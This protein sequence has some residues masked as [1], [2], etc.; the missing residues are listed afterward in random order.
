M[1]V[2]V[3]ALAATN[4]SARNVLLGHLSCLAAWTREEHHFTVLHHAANRDL[5]RDLGDHVSWHSAPACTGH[6]ARRAAW[7]YGTL[8]GLIEELGV[9]LV[10]MCSGTTLP[11]CPVPQVVMALNPWAMV[12]TVH[13]GAGERAK[14]ILQR[15]AYRRTVRRADMIGY[16]SGYLQQLYEENAG[17]SAR[18]S[19]IVYAGLN[20][21]VLTAAGQPRFAGIREPARVVCAS[22]MAPHK[23]VETVV[24]AVHTLREQ[25]GTAVQLYIVGG[26]V[27]SDHEQSVRQQVQQRGLQD[28]VHFTGHV[29]RDELFE[30]YAR[31]S[32][33]CLMSDCESFGIPAVEAQ[34]FGT[35]VVCANCC[36]PPEICGD[37]G[38]YP[39]PG[40]AA[41]AA[42]AMNRLLTETELWSARSEAAVANASRY[43][44]DEISR[45]WMSMFDL[46]PAHK[47]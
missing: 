23:G 26:W 19:K 32:V 3:N 44:Y 5:C 25:H 9:D 7:E 38:L 12:R 31:A 14:A 46:V 43:R 13:I 1:H 18:T 6:W 45:E 15:W 39:A 22:L 8:P 10:F 35:P 11:R 16:I 20:E 17:H 29:N 24:D 21:D 42:D 36:A 33:F 47:P 34:A 2:L 40:D 4:L 28:V 27:R 41:A 37:G 30:H